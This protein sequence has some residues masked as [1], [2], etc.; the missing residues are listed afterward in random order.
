MGELRN[1]TKKYIPFPA[2]KAYRG[3]TDKLHSFLTSAPDGSGEF[4]AP[5]PLY[6][7]E[8]APVYIQL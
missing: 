2:K 6:P 5:G 3:S 1:T 8:R 7:R 4:H